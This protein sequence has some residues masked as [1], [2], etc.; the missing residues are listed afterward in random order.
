MCDKTAYQNGFNPCYSEQVVEEARTIEKSKALCEIRLIF[1]R[2]GFTN[3]EQAELIRIMG[4]W[5]YANRELVGK[6]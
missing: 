4:N 3:D 2:Y 5:N 1:E 6:V